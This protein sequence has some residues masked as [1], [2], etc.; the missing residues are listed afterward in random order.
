V[1]ISSGGKRVENLVRILLLAPGAYGVNGGIALYIRDI[2]DALVENDEVSE[3]TVLPQEIQRDT[4][5]IPG[6]VTHLPNAAGGKIR[7]VALAL[8]Q[9][10]RHYDL[11]LCGHINLMP[12]AATL[13]LKWRAPMAVM[14]Y[15]I[16]VWD[17]PNTQSKFLA[18]RADAIWSISEVTTQRMNAWAKLPQTRYVQLPNAIQLDRYGE[19]GNQAAIRKRHD[20]VGRTLLMTLARL[21]GFDRYKGVDEILECLP[22]LRRDNPS[23]AYMV[24]GDGEDRVRLEEKARTL[25]VAE[26]VRFVGYVDEADKA[27]YYRAADLFVL[28]GRGEGF[29]FVF[30]EALAC[31]V[32]CVGSCIDGSKEALRD[33]LLGEIPDPRDL[34]QILAA[35]RIALK[36]PRGIPAALDY[37]AW[38][39]FSSRVRDAVAQLTSKGAK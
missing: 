32:P 6:K 14:V 27:D 17:Q 22:E 1:I 36:K 11:I 34:S 5:D 39:G 26:H 3:I 16:D 12:L 33:G 18:G 38:P 29:G 28:P 23:I 4:G 10:A 31:G 15:G 37:F 13:N 8:A 30:L 19:Q 2:I 24:V 9:V 21:P 7:F 25:G 20:L 35:I